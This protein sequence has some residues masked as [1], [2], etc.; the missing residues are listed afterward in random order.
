MLLK[1]PSLTMPDNLES[2]EV[3][4]SRAT[5]PEIPLSNTPNPSVSLDKNLTLE[6]LQQYLQSFG[7]VLNDLA[8]QTNKIAKEA[9]EKA[10]ETTRKFEKIEDRIEQSK[11][12]VIE[13][14]GIFVAL[15]TFV[16]SEI[17]LFKSLQF[18]EVLLLS[19][20]LLS[21]M[22]LLVSLLH[23]ALHGGSAPNALLFQR[24]LYASSALLLFLLLVAGWFLLK[25]PVVNMQSMFPIPTQGKAVEVQGSAVVTPSD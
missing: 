21:S 12:S 23:F 15:F 22:T 4:N 17:T 3:E 10:Q 25:K 20:M 8:Q 6:Q 2:P 7:S 19:G 18:P 16:A 5:Q 13:T 1:T 11:I 9:T 24:I 14:I